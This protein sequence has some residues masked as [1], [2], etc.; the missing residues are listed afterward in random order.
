MVKIAII[1][2]VAAGMSAAAAARREKPDAETVVFEK[3]EVVSYA[4]CILPY[5]ISNKIQD[6][7]QL[8]VHNADYFR[9]E[10]NIDVRTKSEV[11][12]IDSAMHFIVVKDLD[13]NEVYEYQ[14]DKLIIAVGAHPLM[15]DFLRGYDNVQSLHNY[16][17]ALRLKA[18]LNSKRAKGKTNAVIIGGGN[19]G[20]ELAE[21]LIELDFNVTLLEMA[22]QILPYMSKDFSDELKSY[23]ESK[24][25]KIINGERVEGIESNL[26]EAAAVITDKGQY[27][28][29]IVI[30]A[31][32]VRANTDFLK[33]KLA[34]GK[35]GAVKV[36]QRQRTSAN[37]VFA[38]GDCCEKYSI[39]RNRFVFLPLGTYANKEGIIAGEN[40]AG[41]FTRN[42]GIEETIVSKVFDME[43][44]KTG[45]PYA[46]AAEIG[47]CAVLDAALP[48]L[49]GEFSSDKIKM[50]II[51]EKGNE[52]ILGAQMLGHFGVAG[53]L[54]VIA[55]AILNNM[56]V[57]DIAN[58]DFSYT[59]RLKPVRDP[60]FSL[61]LRRI[62]A[63]GLGVRP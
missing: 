52:H 56:S 11:L 45:L 40:A 7:S 58:I 26:N 54:D 2:G 60:L 5:Y 28:A 55:A 18:L 20:I 43:W 14:Y 31:L 23:F 8:I 36:D 4:M 59:P 6:E 35:T 46:A 33:N 49:P 10:M 41:N 48:L 21:S 17:S 12:D 39:V 34:L 57:K 50:Q 30:P 53:R 38:C 63:S 3:S 29:D 44:G 19:V 24:G 47:N 22:D 25:I 51:Y 42:N 27:P 37:S 32:G 13:K 1:G 61:S 9:Q 16:E 15:P 62:G